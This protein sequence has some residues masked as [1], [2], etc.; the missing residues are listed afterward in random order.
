MKKWL[1]LAMIAFSSVRVYAQH[2]WHVSGFVRDSAGIGIENVRIDVTDL[3][4][5]AVTDKNGFFRIRFIGNNAQILR[6]SAIN[7]QDKEIAIDYG[8]SGKAIDIRLENKDFQ[9]PQ[10]LVSDNRTKQDAMQKLESKLLNSIPSTGGDQ[11][12]A[13]IKT[14]PGVASGNELTSSYSVRGGNY[15]ENLVYI[16][17]IEIFKPVLLQ[18]GQQEGLGMANPDLVSKIDFSSGGFS[19]VY[20]DKM[21]SVLDIK[22]RQPLKQRAGASLSLLGASAYFEGRN[23]NNK[24][25]YSSGIRY[26]NAQYL[27]K[28]LETQGE[29]KPN[30]ADFQTLVAYQVSSKWSINFFAYHATNNFLFFPKDQRTSFGTLSDALSLYIDFDGSEKD[31]FTST[32]GAIY[33]D[34]NISGNAGLRLT[35]ALY[36]NNE[37]LTYDIQGRYSLNQLDKQIGS[38]TFGDSIMNLGIGR[39]IDHARSYYQAR[40][41]NIKQNGWWQIGHSMLQWG[42]KYQRELVGDEVNEWKLID[43]AG[44]SLPNQ[45][46]KL[47]LSEAWY[48]DN[49]ITINRFNAYLHSSYKKT[50][51]S[52]WNIDFGLRYS[53]SDLNNQ[54]LFSPRLS[55]GWFP[56]ANRNLFIRFGGGVYYQSVVFREIIDRQGNAHRNTKTPFSIQYQAS[57]DYDFNMM[58]RPFHF[59]AE[60]YL[61]ALRQI[62]P[63]SVDNIRTIYYPGQTAKG[64]AGGL[65]LRLNGEFV[66]DVESWLSVSLMNSGIDIFGDTLAIQPLPNDHFLNVSLY[67]Q[68]YIPGNKRFKMYLALFYLTGKPFGP[69]NNDGYYAP[70]R[71]TDYKRADIGF[72]FDMMP[73]YHQNIGL[74]KYFKQALVNV[75]VFNLLGINNTVSY[76][77]VK[78][79]P[80]IGALSN[81]Q[82]SSVAVPN[83]LSTRRLNLRIIF[84]F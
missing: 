28:S 35:A 11:I 37:A 77:W 41:Y 80:N 76:N 55:F 68:D 23:I 38:S 63:Y 62:I 56:H 2:E 24:L 78:I 45:N 29:Y 36:N 72:S 74:K 84:S 51:N 15:D 71:I 5:K 40:I 66:P 73:Q 32:T 4:Q 79:V 82:Y 18:S 83:R 75:E 12:Q 53:F 61:K 3:G 44:F 31:K 59:R 25:L 16:N 52:A 1:L 6:F 49:Q 50:G 43:S 57:G 34:W 58:G 14:M 60:L 47:L 33:T 48:S 42:L 20:D 65:D 9:I 46:D 27:L 64:Y 67:F 10:V 70:L 26:K 7:Y 22:Y 17:G 8:F 81:Q 54:H 13:M 69:P 30:F 39:Y 19:V 21:S